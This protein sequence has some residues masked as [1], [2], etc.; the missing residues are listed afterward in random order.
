MSTQEL[1]DYELMYLF[2]TDIAKDSRF[3]I[4]TM[5]KEASEADEAPDDFVWFVWDFANK[6]E[7]QGLLGVVNE[8]YTF[9]QKGI[10][11]ID[12]AFTMVAVLAEDDDFDQAEY[13]ETLYKRL[14]SN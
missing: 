1:K 14:P 12:E 6:L 5:Y 11:A 2:T 13:K 7:K 4:A 3:D 9:T 10:D 8:R